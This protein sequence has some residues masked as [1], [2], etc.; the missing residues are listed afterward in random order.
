MNILKVSNGREIFKMRIFDVYYSGVMSIEAETEEEARDK[1]YREYSGDGDIDQ[2]EDVT[3]E[4]EDWE[5]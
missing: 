4:F 5:K 1:F 2:I 3:N